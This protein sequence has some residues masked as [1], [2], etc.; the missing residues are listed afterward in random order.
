MSYRGISF[1]MSV[2]KNFAPFDLSHVLTPSINSSLLLKSWQ[3]VLHV[4]KQVV[5][6]W[7]EIRAVRRVVKQLP[8]EML[9]QCS[10]ASS[11]C[12]RVLSWKTTVRI[13]YVSIPCLLFWM[14]LRSLY[15]VS[16]YISDVIVVTFYMNS[17]ISTSFPSQ[18]KSCYQLSGRQTTF[19]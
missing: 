17:T 2:S 16:Q 18:K 4:G 7:S 13:P 3:P 14:A 10:S 12:G 9:P 5:V 15:T 11:W 19:V 1:C 6:A 8:V